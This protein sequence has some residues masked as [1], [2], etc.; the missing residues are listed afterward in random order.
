MSALWADSTALGEYLKAKGLRTLFWA[1]VNTD[2]CVLGSLVDAHS[3]GYDSILVKDI[4][5]TNSNDF[6]KF[7][8][9]FNA[10]LFGFT[11]TAAEYAA[12]LKA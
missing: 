7:S 12:G 10:E 9:E 5:G 6:C 3:K 8:S 2:Q 4:C 11:T 1:G